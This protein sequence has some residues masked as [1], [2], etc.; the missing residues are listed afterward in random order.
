MST[1]YTGAFFDITA[2][3]IVGREVAQTI[4]TT[5]NLLTRTFP[6]GVNIVSGAAS[7]D[8]NAIID[9][10]TARRVGIAA[11]IAM[12]EFA[13]LFAVIPTDLQQDFLWKR[14][15]SVIGA[16]VCCTVGTLVPILAVA[17]G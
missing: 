5:Y 16:V 14:T 10:D 6:L 2:T 9:V 1:L 17:G 4:T 12:S 8:L 15:Y 13:S 7:N 3:I 11:E